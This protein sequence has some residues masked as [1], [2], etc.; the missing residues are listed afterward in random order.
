MS[1][2]EDTYTQFLRDV[3]NVL[4]EFNI[5][6]NMEHLMANKIT[7]LYCEYCDKHNEYILNKVAEELSK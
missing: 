4:H 1:F 3:K 5:N 6:P 7:N 2:Y